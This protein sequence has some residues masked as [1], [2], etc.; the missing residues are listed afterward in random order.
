[1]HPTNAGTDRSGTGPGER[2]GG[3]LP[4]THRNT[5][6]QLAREAIVCGLDGE[7]ALPVDPREY[8][9]EL[10]QEGA[11]FVTLEIQGRLRGCIG[12][13]LARR[14]LVEDVAAN[15]FA[16]AFRDPRFP[17]LTPEEL[18]KLDLHISWLAP[19]VPLSVASREELLQALRPGVDGLFLEDPPYRATF[20][21]QVWRTLSDPVDFL[22]E[23]LAKAGLPRDHWSDTLRFSVYSVEEF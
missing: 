7:K 11:V 14:S 10:R 3:R 2:R 13:F 21:P 17:P 16:A 22:E 19:P 20:L 15:A 1:M 18:S 6:L 23:L 4:E 5:L 8:P 9:D 12:S